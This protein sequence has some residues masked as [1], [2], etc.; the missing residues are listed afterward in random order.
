MLTYASVFKKK[1]IRCVSANSCLSLLTGSLFNTDF[2]S[3]GQ[4]FCALIEAGSREISTKYSCWLWLVGNKSGTLRCTFL[5]KWA[6]PWGLTHSCL[7]SSSFLC[8]SMTKEKFPVCRYMPM[9]MVVKE[10]SFGF[11]SP[12]AGGLLWKI[13]NGKASENCFN[14][15]QLLPFI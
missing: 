7:E 15:S 2:L 8:L 6:K 3:Y 12:K 10:L 11:E 4:F 1:I 5:C 9:H 14:L 13:G